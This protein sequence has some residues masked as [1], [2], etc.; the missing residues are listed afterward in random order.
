[1]ITYRRTRQATLGWTRAL[2]G[3]AALALAPALS[4]QVMAAAAARAVAPT[5]ATTSVSSARGAAMPPCTGEFDSGASI[6]VAAGKST[7]LDLRQLHLSAPAWLRG[8]GDTD[9]VK[10]EPMATAQP[11]FFLFGRKVGA[12]NLMFQ[13]RDG[14]CAMVDVAVGVDGDALQAALAKLMPEQ[15]AIEVGRA[16]DAIVLRGTVTDALAVDRVIAIASAFMRKAGA[17]APGGGEHVVNLLSVAAPQQVMLEVKVAEIS[18]TLVDQLGVDFSGILNRGD[19]AASLVTNFLSNSAGTLTLTKKSSGTITVDAERRDA[20]VKVLAEPNIMAIS[21]QEGSFLAGGKIFIPVAQSNGG[22]AVTITLEEKEFGIGL[23]FTPTVLEGGRINLKVAP[24][25]SELSREGVGISASGVG[26]NAVLPFVT[27]RRAATT[28]QLA[29]GQSFAIAGLIKNNVTQNIKA[30]PILGELPVLGALF[31]SSNFQ[32]D[33]S[34]L[35][36]VITP[37]LVKPL[38]PNYTLPTDH[39]SAPSRG[40]FFLQGKME[41]T[42]ASPPPPP[43][44]RADTPAASGFDT[45]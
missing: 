27:T 4:A 25:V 5:A 22:G 44:A 39:F 38:A 10:V 7:P 23:R 1:M 19:W 34:E 11:V 28:V 32:T 6:S 42:P 31:R 2:I 3:S 8:I 30:F 45:N 20:L 40:E 43:G 13:N 36:F 16:A 26:G 15:N 12:T 17:G 18:K 21:G 9:I 35:V 41:G 24:E 29:D 37:R 33:K 14:R